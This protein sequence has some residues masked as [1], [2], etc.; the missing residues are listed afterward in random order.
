ML[1]F[2]A[3]SFETIH[4]N[5]KSIKVNKLNMNSVY[6]ICIRVKKRPPYTQYRYVRL[7]KRTS[8]FSTYLSESSFNRVKRKYLPNVMGNGVGLWFDDHLIVKIKLTYN[9]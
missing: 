5:K 2:I 8:T 4:N 6:R 1:H 7:K 3:Q 9:L